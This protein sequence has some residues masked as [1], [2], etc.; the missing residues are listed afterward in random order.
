MDNLKKHQG[1]NQF[2]DISLMTSAAVITFSKVLSV[3]VVDLA[4][5]PIRRDEVVL[6]AAQID[7][8]LLQSNKQYI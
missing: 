4:Q 7:F 3:V 5:A 1:S 6:G 8:T 2:L